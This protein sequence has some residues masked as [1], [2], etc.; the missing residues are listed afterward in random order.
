MS[1]GLLLLVLIDITSSSFTIFLV[2]FLGG[3]A[4]FLNYINVQAKVETLG[5]FFSILI[6]I[7]IPGALFYNHLEKFSPQEDSSIN[8]RHLVLVV[9]DGWPIKYLNT[10][11]PDARR[12]K[13]DSL[14]GRGV[15]FLRPLPGC[16]YS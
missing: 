13:L 14:F 8:D 1:I 9:L 7:I 12:S 5:K 2:V 10:Y 11:N 4:Y 6:L 3:A 15:V 16:C